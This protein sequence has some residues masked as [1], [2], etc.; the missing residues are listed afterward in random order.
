MDFPQESEEAST[1]LGSVYIQNDRVG[2]DCKCKAKT[3]NNIAKVIVLGSVTC[4]CLV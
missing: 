3:L 2:K 4:L 1:I